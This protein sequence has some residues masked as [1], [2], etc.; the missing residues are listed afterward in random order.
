MELEKPELAA[1]RILR[2]I[3]VGK[4]F[5]F[6]YKLGQ[7]TDWTVHSLDEF[8]SALKDVDLKSIRFH[9]K[10]GDFERWLRQVVGDDILADELVGVS[11]K[12]LK[13]RKLRKS[14]LDLVEARIKELK[15]MS[16]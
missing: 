15:E 9:L 5:T 2:Q 6:F 10:R 12:K 13:G 16:V 1:K 3:P 4:G 7:P 11:K 8:Y 14:V